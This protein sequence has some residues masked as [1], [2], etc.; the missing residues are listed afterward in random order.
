[1]NAR[2]RKIAVSVP[3]LLVLLFVGS[4]ARVAPA[5]TEDTALRQELMSFLEGGRQS[6]ALSPGHALSALRSYPLTATTAYLL[7]E[8]D[9][10]LLKKYY[11]DIS[12]SVMQLFAEG[13]VT[14]GGLVRAMPGAPAAAGAPLSPGLNALADLELYSLHLIASRTGA[15]EDALE[16]LAWSNSLS[17]LI[18]Q[19]F[20][21]PRRQCFYP[22]ADDGKFVTTYG[23]G[24]LLPLVLDRTLGPDERGK[25]AS[26]YLDRST[27]ARVIKLKGPGAPDPWD[28]SSMRFTMLGL[29]GQALAADGETFTALRASAE[30]SASGA[31]A[32]QAP[33]IDYWRDSR[34]V[35]GRLFPGWKTASSLVNLTLLFERENLVPPKEIAG[36]RS[37]VDSLVTVLSGGKMTLESYRNAT[38]V[39]NNLLAWISR[40]TELFDSSKERWR[41]LDEVRWV[42]LS[43]RTKRLITETLSTSRLDLVCAKADLSARFERDC[44]VIFR[45]E[46]PERP[47]LPGHPIDFTASLRTVRDTLVASQFYVQVGENRWKM[48]ENDQVVTLTPGGAPLRYE[49][50]VSLPPA[51]EPGI[52]TL[53]CTIDFLS[54]GRRLEIHRVAS[55]ALTKEY[56]VSLDMPEG[57]RIVDKPV[58]V[59]ISLTYKTDHDIRGTVEGAFLREFVTQPPL[60]ARFLMSKDSEHTDLTLTVTPKGL[61]S[62]GRYPFSLTVSLDGA[63]VALLEESLVRP[64]RWLSIG[65]FAKADQA[66]RDALTFQADILKTYAA[67][68][69]RALRWKEAPAGAID[70]EGSL[71]PQRLYGK[72]PASCML[73]YTAVDAPA[74]MKLSWKLA[75]KNRS[76]LWINSEPLVPGPGER[77]DETGGSVELRKGPNSFLIAVS[78]DESPDRVLFELSDEAGLPPTG[79]SNEL[80]A[81]VEGYDRLTAPENVK[82]AE[83]SAADQIT[84][85]VIKYASASAAEVSIIGS[86]NNWEPGATLMKREANGGWTATLQLRPG[87]Y[88]YKLL[89]DRKQRIVDPSNPVTEPDGFGG[90]NSVLEVR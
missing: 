89:V 15:Y 82:K 14:S 20:Y 40:F 25:I 34:L 44:G 60:P 45:L 29:L 22:V 5:Q 26:V 63:P 62:P 51:T 70:A 66:M 13:N 41:V 74:R 81:I 3:G 68:D 54:A 85:I 35:P 48:M 87:R 71:W 11:P 37:G 30:G 75:T 7:L 43:P 69:G 59:Q 67:A 57:R 61:V 64:F 9:P 38:G 17:D 10:A 88:S 16:F 19:N 78:W 77:P 33:W 46:V 32:K 6:S 2:A 90:R 27:T 83:K 36:L 58:P 1:M 73:L 47:I 72:L 31:A 80:G 42:R 53:P 12:R 21:D 24:Q 28:D 56:D 55:V 39:V 79:M 52:I 65:P 4:S 84:N 49:G 50:K 23:P 76:L 86:F 8:N 18:I